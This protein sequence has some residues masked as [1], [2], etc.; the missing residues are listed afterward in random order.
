MNGY[1]YHFSVDHDTIDNTDIT[2]IQ[3][4]FIK[5]YIVWMFRFSTQGFIVLLLCFGGSSATKWISLNNQPCTVR[6][7]LIDLNPEELHYY[8]FMFSLERCDWSC[9]T[10]EVLLVT[11]CDE[12]ADTPETTSTNSNEKTNCWHISTVLLASMRLLLLIVIAYY[13]MK[14]RSIAACLLSYEYFTGILTTCESK[15]REIEMK[16]VHIFFSWQNQY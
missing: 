11:I 5:K 10:V 4:Y 7:T 8:P 14:Q 9:N 15:L 13:C 3:D 6:P 1:V 16:I 2:D 12:I